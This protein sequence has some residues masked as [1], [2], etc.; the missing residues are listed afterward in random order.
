LKGGG[1]I[2]EALVKMDAATAGCQLLM[3]QKSPIFDHTS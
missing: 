2:V 3:P 1:T